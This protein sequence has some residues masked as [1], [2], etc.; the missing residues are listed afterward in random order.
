MT[1][2]LADSEHAY[3]RNIRGFLLFYAVIAFIFLAI[4]PSIFS[5]K[6][7]SSQNFHASL[8][9][10]SSLI[11]LISGIACLM[12]F[13]GLHN[14]YFL[15][16][17]LGFFLAGSED[18]IHGILSF[19]FYFLG[20]AVDFSRFIP[21]TYAVGRIVLATMIIAASLLE[22]VLKKA[23]N[24]KRD[25]WFY[26]CC[27]VVFGGGLTALAFIIPLPQFIF[28]GHLISRPLDFFSAILFLIA[29][30]LMLKRYLIKND[31][32]TGMLLASIMFNLGGQVCLSFSENLYDA[33]FDVA[34]L[35]K[36]VGYIMPV[37]GISVQVLEE[38]KKSRR[39][40]TV[41]KEAEEELEK[42]REHLEDLVKE[43]TD[44][45]KIVNEHLKKEID[46][47]KKVAEEL[48]ESQ[49]QL[50]QSEKM[51]SI[52]QLSAGIAHEINNPV[53]FVMSNLG[54]LTDYVGTMKKLLVLYEKLVDEA[55]K[56][57]GVCSKKIIKEIEGVQKEEDLSYILNDVNQLLTESAD[58][59]NR[60][61]GI[62]QSLKTFARTDEVEIKKADINKGLEATLK[63][64]WNE[65][66]YKCQVH[67]KF[68]KIPRILCYPGQLNQVFM[69][70]L[71]NAVQAIPERGDITIET[72]LL[73]N[74][75]IVRITDTGV[76]V[77]P[78]N[79]P[80][81][82]D[83]FFTTKREDK[84]TGLGLSVSL[85]IVEKHKGKME[86]ESYLGK[87]TAFTIYL[88]VNGLEN[89]L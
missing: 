5:S 83:P 13:F 52:G 58:G 31:L 56:G 57:K 47:H 60:I 27:A 89:G 45:L 21:G 19:D 36:V 84:G 78:D 22:N 29:F 32:F 1:H 87:G 64:V 14:R 40:L 80:R 43:R 66:K 81:I 50:V 11:A 71:V 6:W 73:D 41:R 67:K 54:T 74:N 34:N 20:L 72:E 82:F 62:I 16:I 23:E 28:L 46:E 37:L 76:G 85:G 9:I 48:M 25:A 10:V 4:G 59:M 61:R 65:L 7:A 68:G 44:T 69:N 88:P 12:Y 55:K 2:K 15:F 42:Y 3:G 49:T 51:A 77:S 8:D 24:V 33:F 86:V 38:M 39:E 17:G 18:L 79:I 70:L 30:V 75:V 26:S 35:A 63:V 53:G